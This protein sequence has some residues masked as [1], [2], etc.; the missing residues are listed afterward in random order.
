M[1]LD[2]V[3]GLTKEREII[4]DFFL[5]DCET[6]IRISDLKNV[7]IEDGF[8]VLQVMENGSW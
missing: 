7:K 4:R 8:F 6:G 1:K 2:K 5:I 3:P